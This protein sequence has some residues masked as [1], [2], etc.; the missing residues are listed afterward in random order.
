MTASESEYQQRSLVR[1]IEQPGPIT[2]WQTPDGPVWT[3]T[4]DVDGQGTAGLFHASDSIRWARIDGLNDL[5][6]RPGD[7]VFDCGA[8]IGE[9]TRAALTFGARLVVAFEPSSDNVAALKNNLAAEIAAGRVIVIEKGVHDHVG[10][11]TFA[12]HV[13]GSRSGSF[14]D[15][16][17]GES[18]P[19]TTIDEVVRELGLTD[20]D[21]IKMDI[22]GAEVPA[23]RGAAETI[24]R[25]APRLAVGTYHRPTDLSEV[26]ATVL[27]IRS[28]Y[29]VDCSRCLDMW[30]GRL[31]PNLLY[32]E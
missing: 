32:F 30:H 26:E 12:R 21:F 14:E 11:L 6:V 18:L 28:A 7:V 29:K 27:A 23:L 8:H 10:T 19:I 31:F 20:V 4:R 24:R 5:I 16:A 9:S 25:F 22:E 1:L 17:A 13:P 15:D 2:K 3:A